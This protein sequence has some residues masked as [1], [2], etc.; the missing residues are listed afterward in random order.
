MFKLLFLIVFFLFWNHCFAAKF[1]LPINP[2]PEAI[3]VEVEISDNDLFEPLILKEKIEPPFWV[4]LPTGTYYWRIRYKNANTDW[5][6]FS[7]KSRLIVKKKLKP[8]P[9]KISVE[10]EQNEDVHISSDVEKTFYNITTSIKLSSQNTSLV[11]GTLKGEIQGLTYGGVLGWD[12]RPMN[13]ETRLTY[14]KS[15]KNDESIDS[16]EIHMNKYLKGWSSVSLGVSSTLMKNRYY[17][18]N[19]IDS[20]LSAGFIGL[21]ERIK[22]PTD[23]LLFQFSQEMALPFFSYNLSNQLILFLYDKFKLPNVKIFFNRVQVQTSDLKVSSHYLGTEL[24]Y[25]F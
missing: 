25:L 9:I 4:K 2:A 18:A 7:N 14:L 21:T 3:D 16:L 24:E 15:L 12:Y 23:L 1:K 19:F 10:D 11:V 8:E 5:S 22:M 13:I 17:K 6:D 20:D